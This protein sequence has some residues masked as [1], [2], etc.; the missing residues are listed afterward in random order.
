MQQYASFSLRSYFLIRVALV[1]TCLILFAN[2]LSWYTGE[3]D[4]AGKPL[5]G[6]SKP[7]DLHYA[8][9]SS[10]NVIGLSAKLP[11][12]IIDTP[13]HQRGVRSALERSELFGI[14]TVH[15]SLEKFKEEKIPSPLFLEVK[16]IEGNPGVG[17][18][19]WAYASIVFLTI[20]PSG[21]GSD[22]T[23]DFTLYKYD[24]QGKTY[25]KYDGFAYDSRKRTFM[26]LPV[27]LLTP[28]NILT[29][30]VPEIVEISTGAYLERLVRTKKL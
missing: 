13:E 18:M 2:C 19:I 30:D 15:P 5:S 11:T 16:V 7:I 21:W 4:Y 28:I 6:S 22:L 25:K 12:G 29:G 17:A 20:P 26:W 9:I 14:T 23:V 27:I 1:S 24:E 3:P 10:I 8:V